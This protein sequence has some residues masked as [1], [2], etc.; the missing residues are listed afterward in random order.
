MIEDVTG[1]QSGW[2]L[3]EM[4]SIG[5]ENL[6]GLHVSRYDEKE[7][8]D[9]AA[10]V[11]FL[12]SAGLGQGAIVVDPSPV[13][14]SL[15]REKAL[16]RSAPLEIVPGRFL[17]CEHAGV[18][19]DGSYLR[20]AGAS[21]RRIGSFAALRNYG[22]A[23]RVAKSLVRQDSPSSVHLLP[24]GLVRLQRPCNPGT[25]HEAPA[26]TVPWARGRSASTAIGRCPG[27]SS[28][29]PH[30]PRGHQNRGQLGQ[31]ARPPASSATTPTADPSW[32]LGVSA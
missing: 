32:T 12:Q 26:S 11:R 9:T 24:A 5:R 22:H 1:R 17:T 8:A 29:R 16:N 23:D 14:L 3:D 30:K 28:S 31:G 25:A 4:T 21:A 27:T 6:D 10:E 20:R 2:L 15:L 7:D 18:A 19:H 13:M